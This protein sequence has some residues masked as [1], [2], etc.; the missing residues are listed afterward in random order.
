MS[1]A[2]ELLAPQKSAEWFE[3]R[4]GVVT[5]SR[6][7][8]ILGNNPHS[9][10]NDVMREM[11]RE[12]LG[13]PKEFTGNAATAHGELHEPVARAAYEDKTGAFH[14]AVGFLR[15]GRIGASPDGIV[16]HFATGKR[17]LLEIKCPYKG[18]IEKTA[19]KQYY[20]DQMQLTMHVANID[21][22]DFVI[23]KNGEPLYIETVERDYNWIVQAQPVIDEFLAEF[24]R[25]M[26]DTALQEPFGHEVAAD[27]TG[28]PAWESA[29]QE[30]LALADQ[31]KVLQ[32]QQEVFKQLMVKMAKDAGRSA[33]GAKIEV[34]HYF[35]K[36]S[37]DTKRMAKEGID[38]DAYR[39]IDTEIWKCQK[40][41]AK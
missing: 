24:D 39:G 41:K 12:A 18:S 13:L 19:A 38:V 23:W 29:E 27:M 8:A 34:L 28:D 6:I 5:G 11:V 4:I 14:E 15:L 35:Q 21:E 25:I 30:Y 40:R 16:H 32:D 7:G 36:G 33:K 22:C 26:A 2:V 1:A 17:R 10:R 20:R 3:Q 31:I 9:S 37:V